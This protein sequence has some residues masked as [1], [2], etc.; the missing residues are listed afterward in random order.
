MKQKKLLKIKAWQIILGDSNL[1][2]H[3][4][5]LAIFET[6]KAAVENSCFTGD[7][8][9]PVQITEVRD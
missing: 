6:K 2:H 1:A 7:K 4:Q 8:I 3:Y 9:I 5:A